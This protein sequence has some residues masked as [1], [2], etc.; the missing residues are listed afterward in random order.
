MQILQEQ[1]IC[2]PILPIT[3]GVW[4]LCLLLTSAQSPSGFHRLALSVHHLI[5]SLWS[6]ALQRARA[7]ST[8]CLTGFYRS[9]VKQISPDKNMNF[10]STLA[11]CFVLPPAPMQSCTTA[12]FTVILTSRG[13]VILCQLAPNLRLIGCSCSSARSFASGF[14]RNAPRGPPFA[15]R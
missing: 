8:R 1:Y 12:S 14:L 9:L 10:S 15:I 6:M 11:S 5:C 4:L 13:F 3:E 7:C 2:H